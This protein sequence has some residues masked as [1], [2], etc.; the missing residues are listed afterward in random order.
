MD[1]IGQLTGGVA[2]GFS[3]L[4]TVIVANLELME[5]KMRVFEHSD[6]LK[7]ALDVAD[8]GARLTE[9][10]LAFAR[11]NP[12]EPHAEKLDGL[13]GFLTEML[14][15]TLGATIELQT[16]FSPDPW[17][18]KVD[19]TQFESA[20]VNLAVNARDAMLGGRLF[21]RRDK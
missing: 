12:L 18:V 17:T 20:I 10:L 6:L 14:Q 11:R 15:R 1:A 16:V 13:V 9:R 7:E 2:H 4:L 5:M 8:L 21:D 19:P 3:N